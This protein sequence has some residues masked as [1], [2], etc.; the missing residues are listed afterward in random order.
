MRWVAVSIFLLASGCGTVH[1]G[2]MVRVSGPAIDEGMLRSLQSGGSTE[3]EV[4]Q[5]F[6]DPSAVERSANQSTYVYTVVKR[7]T[8]TEKSLLGSATTTQDLIETWRL[9]FDNGRFNGHD[10]SSKRSE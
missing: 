2:P 8:S 10:I 3:E 4:R 1:D 6:G 5:R 7:R 9:K